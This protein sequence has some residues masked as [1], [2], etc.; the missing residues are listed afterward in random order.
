MV[1]VVEHKDCLGLM[2][3]LAAIWITYKHVISL[4]SID[5]P[6]PV[7]EILWLPSV[8]FFFCLSGFLIWPSI[9]RSKS[10]WTYCKKRFW[11]IYP[12][13]WCAVLLSSIT[14][15]FLYK[16]N[17]E[18]GK[19]IL[20]NFTQSTFFQ[21]W[22]P[23][24]LRSYGHGTPNGPLWT[25]FVIVQFYIVAPFLHKIIAKKIFIQV[26]LLVVFILL[27][28]F[29]ENI[30]A[31]LTGGV[32]KIYGYF[33]VVRYMWL[34]LWGVV[35]YENR[36]YLL[37]LLKK[38]WFLFAAVAYIVIKSG[39]DIYLSTNYGLVSSLLSFAGILGFAY[40]FPQFDVKMDISYAIFIYHMIVVNAFIELG[41]TSKVLYLLLVFVIV[42]PVSCISSKTIGSLGLNKKKSL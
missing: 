42:I 41:Y 9:G 33:N 3:L 4:L 38:Y 6:Y 16:G 17:V 30:R 24:F 2:R 29:H 40:R 39:C 18:W 19:F 11:R 27:S 31:I 13:L 15:L 5:I 7:N 37:C 23:D 8:P 26:C 36:E 25:L 10:F 32:G 1:K 20:F 28:F 12:E 35:L 14:I 21:F 34:F 22:T